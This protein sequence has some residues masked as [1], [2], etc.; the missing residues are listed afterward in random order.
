M[1]LILFLYLTFNGIVIFQVS[2]PTSILWL[3][4]LSIYIITD[5][6]SLIPAYMCLMFKIRALN[7]E[8]K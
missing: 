7:K 5:I 8:G 4:L 3:G 2:D 1:S 6:I